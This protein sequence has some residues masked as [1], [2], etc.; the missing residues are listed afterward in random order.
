MNHSDPEDLGEQDAV[1][2]EMLATMTSIWEVVDTTLATLWERGDEMLVENMAMHF[3]QLGSHLQLC[4]PAYRLLQA[5]HQRVRGY[6]PSRP[7][8]TYL[9]PAWQ[10][11]VDATS[12]ICLQFV[13]WQRQRIRDRD[14]AFDNVNNGL[15]TDIN[16]NNAPEAEIPEE[17]MGG[18]VEDDVVAMVTRPRRGHARSRPPRPNSRAAETAPSASLTESWV[19]FAPGTAPS[20]PATSSS[21]APWH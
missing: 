11:W 7:A 19:G 15:R 13:K 10:D 2:V 6:V 1:N 18:D 5:L 4:H 21:V 17:V 20:S 3:T 16:V 8:L 12:Q 14:M 9:A